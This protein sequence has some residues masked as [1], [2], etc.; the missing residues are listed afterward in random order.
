MLSPEEKKAAFMAPMSLL[1]PIV[2]VIA[3]THRLYTSLKHKL[4]TTI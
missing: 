3:P 1:H 4:N 2:A